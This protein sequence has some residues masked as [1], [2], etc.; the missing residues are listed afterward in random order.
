MA[1]LNCGLEAL[2]HI[3]DLKSVSAYT[4]IHL[5]KDNG[6]SLQVCKVDVEQLPLVAR[7]A[8][9]HANNHFVFVED[10][11]ALPKAKYSGYVLTSRAVGRLV[12]YAEAKQITG[13]KKGGFARFVVPTLLA[14]IPGVG[15]IA[16]GIAAAGMDQYA[17]SNHPEQ[18]GKPGNFLDILKVGG[19]AFLGASALQGGLR[20]L[21]AGGG[22]FLAGASQG[23][24][25][26]IATNPLLSSIG[27]GAGSLASSG[28]LS[29]SVV[30][31]GSTGALGGN[32]GLASQVTAFNKGAPSI[33]SS[34]V[35][36]AAQNASN[37][38]SIIG[39]LSNLSKGSGAVSVPQTQSAGSTIGGVGTTASGTGGGGL[40]GLLGGIDA[41][42]LFGLG[43]TALVKPPSLETDALKQYNAASQ[44]LQSVNLPS[45]TMD[46]LHNYVVSPISDLK[47]QFYNPDSSNSAILALDKQYQEALAQVNRLAANSG[48]SAATSSDVQNQV[49]QINQ[50][51]AESKANLKAQLDQQ[52]TDQALSVK[53][54]ALEQSIQQGR[55]DINAAFELAK[56]MGLQDKLQ[57]DLDRQD[58]QGFQ[59]TIAKLLAPKTTTA[60]TTTGGSNNNLSNTLGS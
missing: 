16:S 55:F 39:G 58:Y 49:N 2:Q 34:T 32:T 10:G 56:Y 43:A 24:Q 15:P 23:L 13:A 5:A 20:G 46:Q 60:D 8:I 30:G 11:Q 12:P 53:K 48:Q 26:P 14:F 27:K 35:A 21:Q 51:W 31:T 22:G 41:K 52:A 42:T 40:S 33:L 1:T 17:K 45:P 29:G 28:G 57:Y 59:D 44:Y 3:K 7:P 50:Q 6:L 18:L 36:G 38:G 54:W 37:A 19:G 4:L 47:T 25:H 9:L